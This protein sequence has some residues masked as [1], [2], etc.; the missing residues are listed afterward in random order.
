MAG[1]QEAAVN[2]GLITFLTARLDEDEAAA[3]TWR[4]HDLRPLHEVEAGRALLAEREAVRDKFDELSASVD[5]ELSGWWA[6]RVIEL[7]RV[8][9]IRAGVYRDH[10][11]YRSEWKP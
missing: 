11:D 6:G 8:I 3:E 9:R 1:G 4:E 10:P 5:R 7:D 2:D